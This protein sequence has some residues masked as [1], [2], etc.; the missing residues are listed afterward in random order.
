MRQYIINACSLGLNQHDAEWT[1]AGQHGAE[2]ENTPLS[3]FPSSILHFSQVAPPDLILCHNLIVNINHIEPPSREGAAYHERLSITRLLPM[4]Y[5]T[6][7]SHMCIVVL[8]L[9]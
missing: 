7:H 9:S 6:K 8:L 2:Y 3:P 5:I 1:Q 4:A